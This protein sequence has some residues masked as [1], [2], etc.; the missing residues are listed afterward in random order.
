MC[1]SLKSWPVLRCAI[2]HPY[3]TNQLPCRD[4]S[5][6]RWIASR[7]GQVF[8]AVYSGILAR[9]FLARHWRLPN[10]I[11]EQP[12]QN[13]NSIRVLNHWHTNSLLCEPV[14]CTRLRVWPEWNGTCSL[15]YILGHVCFNVSLGTDSTRHPRSYGY[16]RQKN[17]LG[18][19]RVR[20][21]GHTVHAN[22]DTR[23]VGVGAHDSF[24]R[25][26]HN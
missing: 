12:W 19:A 26:L 6:P 14:L 2:V 13:I 7:S 20:K 3:N 25:L 18:L 1:S 21:N 22:V 9:S 15:L 10:E 24:V 11:A 8:I 4:T 17:I 23:S 5:G 16:A